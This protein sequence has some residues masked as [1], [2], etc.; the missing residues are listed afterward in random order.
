MRDQT[1]NAHA[2]LLSPEANNGQITESW[3]AG[4][5]ESGRASGR[6]SNIDRSLG[7]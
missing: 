1:P 2:P 4:G 3:Q 7:P 5:G 6:G